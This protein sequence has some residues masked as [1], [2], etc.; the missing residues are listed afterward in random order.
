MFLDACVGNICL[1]PNVYSDQ[2]IMTKCGFVHVNT[3]AC[4]L[5]WRTRFW[6]ASLGAPSR[7][8]PVISSP[9]VLFR[10]NGGVRPLAL[11]FSSVAKLTLA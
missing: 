3:A 1:F 6:P 11:S 8:R 4:P 5:F 10:P 2:Y 7:F 9:S